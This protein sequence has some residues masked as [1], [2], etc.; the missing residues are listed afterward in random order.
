M[1]EDGEIALRQHTNPQ[2]DLHYEVV[3][4]GT[5]LFSTYNRDSE[6]ALARL[7]V[8]PVLTLRRPLSVL[9]GGLGIGYTL[10]AI[11]E[12]KEVRSAT[13]V[14]KEEMIVDWCKTYFGPFNGGSIEDPRV[15]L[16]D[17]DFLNFIRSTR[18]TYDSV[19]L[20]LDNG[21]DWLVWEE[22]RVLYEESGLN[23]IKNVMA[24]D[25]CLGIWSSGRADL[26]EN[27]LRRVFKNA[28]VHTI[29]TT[30]MGRNVEYYIYTAT[31]QHR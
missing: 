7:T 11:L 19:C 9:I 23:H 30:E 26:F 12:R 28:T 10:R 6:R 17:G 13:V 1:T 4:N 25:G 20:D 18:V 3:V 8:D 2:G 29:N 21:P 22:N 14:E 27:R 24:S 16:V 31:R 5:F 15:S